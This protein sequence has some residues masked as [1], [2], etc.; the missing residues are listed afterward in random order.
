M[1]SINVKLFIQCVLKL[2]CRY[3]CSFSV[4]MTQPSPFHNLVR[5]LPPLSFN[6]MHMPPIC[7]KNVKEMHDLSL[8]VLAINSHDRNRM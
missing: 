2:I 7:I 1:L 5:K 4:H 3:M 8:L 6:C